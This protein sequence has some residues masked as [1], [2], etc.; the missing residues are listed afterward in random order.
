MVHTTTPATYRVPT[1]ADTPRAFHTK[2]L[3]A[4]AN[5][6]R[7]AVFSSKGVGEVACFLG[8]AAYFA[9]RNAVQAARADAGF[10]GAFDLGTPATVRRVRQRLAG[11]C[12]AG[13][14]RSA[15]LFDQHWCLCYCRRIE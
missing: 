13:L 2:L 3:A 14:L 10:T 4:S 6:R 7:K 8:S 5:S 1:I 15:E 11:S 9:L 12:G